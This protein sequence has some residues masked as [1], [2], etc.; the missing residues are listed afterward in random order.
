MEGSRQER[1]AATMA[2]GRVPLV[3]RPP[4]ARVRLLRRIY[5]GARHFRRGSKLWPVAPAS[6][7]ILPVSAP[8]R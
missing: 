7:E 6:L 4:W 2:Q 3:F 5:R 8:R 1:S